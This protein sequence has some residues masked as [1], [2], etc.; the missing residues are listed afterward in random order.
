MRLPLSFGELG[1]KNLEHGKAIYMTGAFPSYPLYYTSTP[2]VWKVK[3]H[4]FS[5]C[6]VELTIKIRKPNNAI[7]PVALEEIGQANWAG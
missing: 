4:W 1:K 7:N 3:R 6:C 5:G 2:L